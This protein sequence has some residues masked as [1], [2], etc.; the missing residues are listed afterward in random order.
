MGSTALVCGSALPE[1][2]V[3]SV[4]FVCKSIFSEAGAAFVLLLSWNT[5]ISLGVFFYLFVFLKTRTKSRST[6]HQEKR[7][8]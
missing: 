5:T 4:I 1:S 2:S 7:L 6:T 3:S 8:T